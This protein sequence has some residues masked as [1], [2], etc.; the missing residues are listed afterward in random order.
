MTGFGVGLSLGVGL[1]LSLG[2]SV[3]LL[4]VVRCI[5]RPIV[6]GMQSTTTQ[7]IVIKGLRWCILDQFVIGG[8][9]VIKGLGMELMMWQRV[10]GGG[11]MILLPVEIIWCLF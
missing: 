3:R 10:G 4:V 8:S 7:S 6:I 5:L 11:K 1:N 2:L 9:I